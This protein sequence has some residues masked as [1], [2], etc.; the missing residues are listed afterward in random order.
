MDFIHAKTVEFLDCNT[1]RLSYDMVAV[2][3][4]FTYAIMPPLAPPPPGFVQK[5]DPLLVE[6]YHRIPTPIPDRWAAG[7]SGAFAPARDK[8]KR[9]PG[10]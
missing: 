1:I 2:Y 4:N 3:Y 8:W 7:H 6:V 5:F 9:W 10:K